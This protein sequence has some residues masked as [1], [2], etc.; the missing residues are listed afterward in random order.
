MFFL[1]VLA[2]EFFS[3]EDG[4]FHMKESRTTFTD[5]L[6]IY[7]WWNSGVLTEDTCNFE[8]YIRMIH[9]LESKAKTSSNSSYSEKTNWNA[10]FMCYN[11]WVFDNITIKLASSQQTNSTL[12]PWY[13][14]C[15]W[16]A[17]SASQKKHQRSF[18]SPQ[19]WNRFGAWKKM[20]WT[21]FD[22]HPEIYGWSLKLMIFNQ[23]AHLLF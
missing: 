19:S 12:V 8:T 15:H 11:P 22:E 3:G 21:C 16:P 6:F 4:V 1:P 13:L 20:W 9:N 17:K 5:V 2:T 10:S 14:L 7:F 18:T 23:K